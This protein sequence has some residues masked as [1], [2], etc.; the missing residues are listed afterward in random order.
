MKQNND[1][2]INLR[3]KDFISLLIATLASLVIF[4][5]IKANFT[6]NM[7]VRFFG[8]IGIAGAIIA[9]STS[10]F[11]SKNNDPFVTGKTQTFGVMNSFVAASIAMLLLFFKFNLLL[12]I[13]IVDLL[14][15]ISRELGRNARQKIL[16]KYMNEVGT[17]IENNGN[18]KYTVNINSEKINAYSKAE[19][20][21]GN[22]VKISELKGSYLYIDKIS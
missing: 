16:D 10:Y 5:I 22:D 18:G 12:A 8:Y 3:R 4:F 7:D 21:V 9:I 20:S 14:V 11:E 1:N 13:I 19:L 17:I 15:F 2:I 6:A